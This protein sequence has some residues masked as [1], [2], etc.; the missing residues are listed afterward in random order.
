MQH[1]GFEARWMNPKTGQEL[2]SPDAGWGRVASLVNGQNQIVQS[3][4]DCYSFSKEASIGKK[5]SQ[6][7]LP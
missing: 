1:S 2:A 7:R 4:I 5:N 3:G 6:K